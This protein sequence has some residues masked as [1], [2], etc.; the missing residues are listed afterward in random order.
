MRQEIADLELDKLWAICPGS[1]EIQLDDKI[2]ARPLNR[3]QA[4]SGC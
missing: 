1:R 2:L 4:G 3:I